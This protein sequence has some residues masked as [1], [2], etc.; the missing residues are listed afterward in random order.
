MLRI[1]KWLGWVSAASPYIL[2][3]GGAVEQV[4]VCSTIPGQLTVRGGMQHA[5]TTTGVC[6]EMWG[7]TNGPGTDK[8]FV[9]TDSGD[10][11]IEDAPSI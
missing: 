11:L 4:N 10:I 5:L 3:A 1:S 6:Q 8:L 2:P 7:Y 9:F